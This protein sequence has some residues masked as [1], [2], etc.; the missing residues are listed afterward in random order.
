MKLR[1]TIIVIFTFLSHALAAQDIPAP[2]SPPRLVND[3][4]GT[5]S[6]AQ[7]DDLEKTLR[8]YNDSTSTQICIVTVND[9]KGYAPS[10]FGTRLLTEWGVGQKDKRNGIVILLKPRMGNERGQVYIAVGYDIEPILNDARVGRIIDNRMMPYLSAGDY[11]SASKAAVDSIIKYL[12]GQ[13]EA[14]ERNESMPVG[15][16]ILNILL[17]IFLIYIIVQTIKNGG[18]G[19]SGGR[20][21]GGQWFPPIIGGGRSGGGSFGGGG[22]FGGF[23]GG[24]GGGGGAGRSF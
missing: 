3:F 5:F 23:G 11:Y 22:G 21:G 20:S 14:D 24:S 18:R 1:Y 13:F 8:A 4:S 17:V 7:R 15:T 19:S 9:L 6:E 2:M 12:S 16:I 10:D